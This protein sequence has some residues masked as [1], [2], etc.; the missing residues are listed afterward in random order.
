MSGTYASRTPWNAALIR[1][2]VVGMRRALT[3]AGLVTAA[4]ALAPGDAPAQA[5][6]DC[7]TSSGDY[8]TGAN[9]RVI[10][11]DGEP[12]EFIVYVPEHAAAPAGRPLVFM[13]HGT[14]GDGARFLRHS[15]WREQA[16]ATGIVAVFPTGL[17]YRIVASGRRV[18]KWND[19][20]LEAQIDP[21]GRPPADDVGFV[22]A[23]LADLR[24]RLPLDTARLYASGFSNGGE[25]TARLAA[26]R[27][28]VFAA[29]GFSAGGLDHVHV[30]DRPI[31]MAL[32]LGTRDDRVL[33]QTGLDELPL[34]PA[35]I[36]A[37]PAIAGT[38]GT[39]LR[40]LGLTREPTQV[41]T[42]AHATR[43][44]WS[45]D[46]GEELQLTMLAGVQ[47]QFPNAH[48]NPAG[49]EA[50]AHFARFFAAHPLPVR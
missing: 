41:R 47:H 30:P 49:F 19:G 21:A 38:L 36:L 7:V 48:N 2:V 44:R 1:P 11:V 8:E 5:P 4:I 39:L 18:T 35:E 43:L 16:D 37:T 23:M 6:I 10:E 50:A 26:E 27:S 32:T 17:R 45:G 14:S 46:A 25:F 31:P 34:D 42:F 3:T 9:C 28:D 12:R 24:A 13:F 22:D 29:A 20:G 40:S 15:G 33:A